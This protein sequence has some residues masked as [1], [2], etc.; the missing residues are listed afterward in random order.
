MK[1]ISR[2]G[3]CWVS[4]AASLSFV[5]SGPSWAATAGDLPSLSG[6]Y[7]ECVAVTEEDPERAFD[8]A[9]IWRDQGGGNP[10]EHCVAMALLALGHAS[11]AAV[12]LDALAREN[13]GSSE[14]ERS[15]LM[16]QAG[17][18]WLLA[19]R[20]DLAQASFSAALRLTPRASEVWAA[21]AR[22]HAMDS[23]WESAEFDLDA[24]I[25]FD[26][27]N[28]EFYVLRSAARASLGRDDLA[29]SDIDAAL[30]IDP[31]FP[32]ALAERGLMRLAAGNQGGAREDWIKVLNGA[33]ESAAADVARSGIEQM[34]IHLEP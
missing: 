24:A 32:D 9:L 28:P 8:E 16:A 11:E 19:R 7:N 12:R 26:N 1:L 18:A 20:A 17:E 30:E 27:A 14:G 33:P 6:R 15:A 31:N 21:R 13:S 34:E 10:A 4:A 23:E 29:V 25:T 5:L 22:A 3:V 2:F